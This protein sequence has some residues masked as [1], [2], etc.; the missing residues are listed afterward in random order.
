[1]GFVGDIQHKYKINKSY[2]RVNL[3]EKYF[4]LY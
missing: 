1:M 2:N 3:R 4:G